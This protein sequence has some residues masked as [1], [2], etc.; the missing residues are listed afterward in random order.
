MFLILLGA[1]TVFVPLIVFLFYKRDRDRTIEFWD[2]IGKAHG[3]P[4]NKVLEGLT[5]SMHSFRYKGRV[6]SFSPK[7]LSEG[8]DDPAYKQPCFFFVEC[9]SDKAGFSASISNGLPGDR[10]TKDLIE[11]FHLNPEAQTIL[12]RLRGGF[13]R[14]D[15]HYGTKGYLLFEQEDFYSDKESMKRILDNLVLLA[16]ALEK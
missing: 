2:E 5:P 16:D 14:L 11:K 9:S 4:I 12:M 6:V 8:F 1:I 13:I 7:P 10:M 3:E 15:K